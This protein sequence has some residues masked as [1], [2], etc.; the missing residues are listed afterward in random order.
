MSRRDARL[1]VRVTAQ[2]RAAIARRARK[3][4]LK[5]SEYVR[6]RCLGDASPAAAPVDA[7][8]LRALHTELRREGTNLNQ[9]AH[10]VNADRIPE[11]PSLDAALRA[12][13]HASSEAAALLAQARGAARPTARSADG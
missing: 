11:P 1:V 8:P 6:R 2:E 3:A 7:G 4:G 5:T 9:I 10:A 12:V 13:A